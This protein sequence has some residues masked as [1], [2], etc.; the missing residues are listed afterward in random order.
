MN[1]ELVSTTEDASQTDRGGEQPCEVGLVQ[2]PDNAEATD[3][4][5]C[6]ICHE[7]E[8]AGMVGNFDGSPSSQVCRHCYDNVLKMRPLLNG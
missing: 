4:T 6:E 1:N 8:S 7:R 3:S 2:P 5:I